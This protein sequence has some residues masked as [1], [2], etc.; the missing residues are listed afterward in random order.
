MLVPLGTGGSNWWQSIVPLVGDPCAAAA[1][2]P[3][4]QLTA[5]KHITNPSHR[6][7]A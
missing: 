5:T 1:W 2:T 7:Q 3:Y 6:F 4:G